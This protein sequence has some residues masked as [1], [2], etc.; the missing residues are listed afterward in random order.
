MDIMRLG[1]SFP[2][3]GV[4]PAIAPTDAQYIWPVPL[5]ELLVNKAAQQNTG[6]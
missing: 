3:K 6:Y 1:L 5:S 4:A 2:A